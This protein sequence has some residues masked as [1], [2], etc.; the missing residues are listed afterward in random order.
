MKRIPIRQGNLRGVERERLEKTDDEDAVSVA[1]F[2]VL[3]A[4]K[5]LFGALTLLWFLWG[6][7][8]PLLDPVPYRA[9]MKLEFEMGQKS[10]VAKSAARARGLTVTENQPQKTTIFSV[11]DHSQ[12]GA[13]EALS[14]FLSQL[15]DSVEPPAP[16]LSD[17]FHSLQMTLIRLEAE[18]SDRMDE[19]AAEF[20][21]ELAKLAKKVDEKKE[22][23]HFVVQEH[24]R[25]TSNWVWSEVQRAMRFVFLW[26]VSVFFLGFGLHLWSLLVVAWERSKLP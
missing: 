22:N 8:R 11:T 4:H 3:R 1:C 25:I 20:R 13:L 15:S 9:E 17:N 26:L 6:V 7:S 18:G 21:A 24:P 5:W 19:N 12:A 23:R 10:S 2:R 16:C 14:D